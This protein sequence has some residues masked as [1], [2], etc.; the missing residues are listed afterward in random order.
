ME[1][2]FKF[3]KSLHKTSIITPYY[4]YYYYYYRRMKNNLNQQHA[5]KALYRTYHTT[6]TGERT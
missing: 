2:N 3:Q 6:R 1:S 4:Y 5:V